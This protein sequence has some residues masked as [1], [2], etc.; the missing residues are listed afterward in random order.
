[1]SCESNFINDIFGII[2]DSTFCAFLFKTFQPL[3][4][5]GNIFTIS[6]VEM[7]AMPA[8]FIG[9]LA[10]PFGHDGLVWQF[11]GYGVTMMLSLSHYVADL[12]FSS[13]VVSV[14]S[15]PTLLFVNAGMIWIFLWSTSLRWIGLFPIMMGGVLALITHH[16]DLYIA[17]DGASVAARGDDGRLHIMGRGVNE[18]TI[19]QWLAAD[20]D[21]RSAQD[22]S[23]KQGPLCS[24]SGCVMNGL[25][26]EKIVLGLERDDLEEDCKLASV[27]ITP[28]YVPCDCNE[29]FVI[30]RDVVNHYG[31]V[32]L[33]RHNNAKQPVSVPERFYL[34][35]AR[36]PNKNRPWAPRADTLPLTTPPQENVQRTP[37]DADEEPLSPP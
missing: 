12:P 19:T 1:V 34:T 33:Y 2:G 17:R 5:I 24:S 3:G 16:P 21:A 26:H 35:G 10:L 31:A 14:V 20:G 28:F 23:V 22:T 8:G 36:D 13:V 29:A 30:D 9:L 27:L 18:F 37:R 6:L 15:V 4:V 25:A 11:M 32:A 7:V